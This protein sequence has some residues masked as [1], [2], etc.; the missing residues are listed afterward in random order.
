MR[1]APQ[2]APQ[3]LIPRHARAWRFLVEFAGKG[4]VT[5]FLSP[6]VRRRDPRW[7]GE[8]FKR[9]IKS[10]K[11]FLPPTN[12][13]AFA[14]RLSGME[15]Y[16]FFVEAAQSLGGRTRLEAVFFAG[17]PPG[18]DRVNLWRIGQGKVLHTLEPFG[19]EYQGEPTRGWKPGFVG[20]PV[21]SQL[22]RL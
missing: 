18:S 8:C 14:T 20:G 12:K 1:A 9:P 17:R 2:K 4:R 21:V 5:E 16:N 11:F 10:L 22:V 19:R 3:I 6:D 13:G 15:Q 7:G